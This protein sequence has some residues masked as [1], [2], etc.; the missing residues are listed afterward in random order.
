MSNLFWIDVIYT[1]FFE[2]LGM[3]YLDH[4]PKKN[5]ILFKIFISLRLIKN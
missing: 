1:Y 3:L 5:S 2:G 4:I